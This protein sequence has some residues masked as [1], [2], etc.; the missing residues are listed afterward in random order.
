MSGRP[1]PPTFDWVNARARCTV[2]EAFKELEQGVQVDVEAANALV[3]TGD[4]L[5]FSI[6][7]SFATHFTVNRID[8]PVRS[9][10]RAIDFVWS[11]NKIEVCNQN[12]QLLHAATLTLTNEGRCKLRV[13]DEELEMWQFRR[14]ALEKLFFGP[15]D[16]IQP[17]VEW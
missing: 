14:M 6:T 15:F 8:D 12:N 17:I 1:I 2:Q 11:D 16:P 9:Q 5:R 7:K 4:P 3:T 13:G 10:G